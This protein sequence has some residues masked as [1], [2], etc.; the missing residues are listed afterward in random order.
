[1]ILILIIEINIF[2]KQFLDLKNVLLFKVI[3]GQTFRAGSVYGKFRLYGLYRDH[4]LAVIIS[5]PASVRVNIKLWKNCI[6][7]PEKN[8]S[9]NIQKIPKTKKIPIENKSQSVGLRDFGLGIFRGFFG[10]QNPKMDE[11]DPQ[12]PVLGFSIRDPEK[13]LS[14]SQ[15]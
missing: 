1:M 3:L 8:L 10:L 6:K 4:P 14:Q 5:H 7:K 15:P 9:I 11:P 2:E 13:N 12:F